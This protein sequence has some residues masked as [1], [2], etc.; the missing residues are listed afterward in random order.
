MKHRR[1]RPPKTIWTTRK[2]VFLKKNKKFS[3]RFHRTVSNRFWGYEFESL[4]IEQCKRVKSQVV[5]FP[6]VFLISSCKTFGRSFVVLSH[7]TLL[8]I[9][10]F[11]DPIVWRPW[12]KTQDVPGAVQREYQRRWYGPGVLQRRYDSSYEGET[13]HLLF[14]QRSSVFSPSPHSMPSVHKFRRKIHFFLTRFLRP[15]DLYWLCVD[16]FNAIVSLG[17]IALASKCKKLGN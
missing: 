16:Q 5:E 4:H 15:S 10:F 12:R 2:E 1:F 11:K 6:I 13:H 8:C 7:L 3:K 9:H 17:L 14:W